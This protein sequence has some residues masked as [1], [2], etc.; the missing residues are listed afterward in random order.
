AR[1]DGNVDADSSPAASCMREPVDAGAA[2]A[3]PSDRR[4]EE[5]DR[6]QAKRAVEA[7]PAPAAV[8]GSQETAGRPIHIY[9]LHP[10]MQAIGEA[11]EGRAACGAVV[12][13]GARERAPRPAPVSRP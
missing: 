7:L 2:A 3:R 10:S 6:R 4:R 5:C 8:N 1:P 13:T 9:G 11:E 12:I